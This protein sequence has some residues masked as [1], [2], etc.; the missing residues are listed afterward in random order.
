MAVSNPRLLIRLEERASCRVIEEFVAAED[1]GQY[2]C[3]AVAEIHL[4]QMSSLRH[5]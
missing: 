5:G 3:N 1:A 4:S 2:F